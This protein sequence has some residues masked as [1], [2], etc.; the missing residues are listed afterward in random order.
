MRCPL[1]VALLFT[2][3]AAA[4]Q[5]EWLWPSEGT[6]EPITTSVTAAYAASIGATVGLFGGGVL[7]VHV[8]GYSP[9]DDLTVPHKIGLGMIGAG[10][11]MGPSLGNV[12]LLG[13]FDP[14]A[15]R[16][17]ALRA[18]A[19]GAGVVGVVIG[20]GCVLGQMG[21]DATD[22]SAPMYVGAGIAVLGLVGGTIYDLAVIPHNAARAREAV[23]TPRRATLAPSGRGLALRVPL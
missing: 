9:D 7:I 18:S 21:G 3:H 19:L 20:A 5:P 23:A 2:S 12:L 15:A 10:V 8:S 13:R 1:L 4:A 11:M 16:G 17:A 22:C 14:S 6:P